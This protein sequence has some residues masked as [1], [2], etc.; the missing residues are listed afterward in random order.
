MPTF[1]VY[2]VQSTESTILE[3]AKK[4]G[5]EKPE[6]GQC[7]SCNKKIVVDTYSEASQCPYCNGSFDTIEALQPI[8]KIEVTKKAVIFIQIQNE[9]NVNKIGILNVA[10][11]FDNYHKTKEGDKRLEGIAE[12]KEEERKQ[13]SGTELIEFDV[14]TREWLKSTRDDMIKAILEDIDM[15]VN[16][17]AKDNNYHMIINSK[18]A[19]L[20]KNSVDITDKVLKIL[21][22]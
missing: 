1:I 21:N 12:Q 17:F 9:N 7:P 4:T 6:I 14:K 22:E 13:Y 10:R 16:K 15:V 8:K 3:S 18:A 20:P 19:V 11:L 5:F 2:G